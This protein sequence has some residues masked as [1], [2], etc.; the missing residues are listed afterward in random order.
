[1][2]LS[3]SKKGCPWDNARI[4]SF[5]SLI[6]REWLNQYK[7]KDYDHAKKLVFKYIEA[8]INRLDELDS[9][10]GYES[11]NQYETQYLKKAAKLVR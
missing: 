5:H 7:I 3:Y 10:C 4:E 8:F 2:T 6:K 9:H 11:P 1:M